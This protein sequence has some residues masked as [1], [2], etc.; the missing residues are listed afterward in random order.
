MISTTD[1]PVQDVLKDI[2]VERHEMWDGYTGSQEALIAAD[3]ASEDM[4]PVWP[5]RLKCYRGQGWKI[6]R[7]RVSLIPSYMLKGD[8]LDSLL[9]ANNERSSTNLTF[10]RHQI[11]E[12]L[13]QVN[14][15]RKNNG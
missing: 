8:S 10:P 11:H 12:R 9:R 3:L 13:D 6:R 2:K 5:K 15:Q 1:L 4:F 7:Q 14:R